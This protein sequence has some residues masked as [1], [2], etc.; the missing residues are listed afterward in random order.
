[1][2]VSR[3]EM[4]DMAA[5]PKVKAVLDRIKLHEEAIVKAREYLD[6]GKHVAR[7]DAAV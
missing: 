7:R 3:E 5:D 4:T 1:M 6:S 2:S